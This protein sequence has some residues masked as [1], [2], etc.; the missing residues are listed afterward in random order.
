MSTFR[1]P[2]AILDAF[3][4]EATHDR[5]TL[6]RYLRQ[7]PELAQ[8]LIDLSSELRLA[9]VPMSPDGDPV[10]DPELE[11]AWSEFFGCK[12]QVEPRTE[13]VNPFA[14]FKGLAFAKLAS[15]L[16]V[17]R[18]FLTAFRDGLVTAS[19]IPEPFTKR[20]ADASGVSVESARDYF[21]QAQPGLAAL[22][23]KSDVKPSHQGQKSF[24]ELVQ[25]TEMTEQQRQL[26]LRECN[27]DGLN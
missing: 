15:A 11:T 16:D 17:P 7:Y 2:E 24:R 20:F 3:A 9:N 23:F 19:S 25:A 10:A 18:V 12:P 1:D 4:V 14:K 21:A 13:A 8:E 26:L 6:E 5:S 22:A 27:A